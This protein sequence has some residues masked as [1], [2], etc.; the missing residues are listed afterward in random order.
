MGDYKTK[1]SFVAFLH[2]KFIIGILN[3]AVKC[4]KTL[5]IYVKSP[6]EKHMD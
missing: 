1:T 4:D 2:V 6:S 5:R 3:F